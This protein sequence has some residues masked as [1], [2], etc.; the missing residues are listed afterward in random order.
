VILEFLQAAHNGAGRIDL[1]IIVFAAEQ[2]VKNPHFKL[3]SGR[4]KTFIYQHYTS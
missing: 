3:L 4:Q 1:G 2:F